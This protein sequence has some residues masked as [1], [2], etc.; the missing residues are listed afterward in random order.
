MGCCAG[1]ALHRS[2]SI[3]GRG[4]PRGTERRR[5]GRPRRSV[6]QPPL[7]PVHAHGGGSGPVTRLAARGAAMRRKGG[8]PS[9]CRR[10]RV[11]PNP[12]D[13][14]DRRNTSSRAPERVP[15]RSP[16]RR[17]PGSSRSVAVSVDRVPPGQPSQPSTT[18]RW[19]QRQRRFSTW[20]P[21]P[22]A[23]EQSDQGPT[24]PAKPRVPSRPE[25]T[26][27]R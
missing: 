4:D 10:S 1:P 23:M 21:L 24:R 9:G 22:D 25:A 27:W 12:R 5:G 2:E 19:P 8:G 17:P 14:P 18:T 6:G 16:R 26:N 13:G 7:E 15:A 3:P 11:P 20:W